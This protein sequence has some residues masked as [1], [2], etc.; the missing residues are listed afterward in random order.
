MKAQ[1]LYG[2]DALKYEENYK[3]PKLKTGEVLISVKACGICGSDVNRVLKNGTYH[4]PTIIGHEFSGKV[5]ECFDNENNYWLGRNVS[6]FPLIPCKVC[7]SCLKGEY[8]L[9]ENYNYLGSR[10]DGG[11]AEYVSVPAW[12]LLEMHKG[13]SFEEA[14]MLEPASV[15]LHS[16]KIAGNLFGKTIVITGTGTISSIL[17]QL[18]VVAGANKVYIIGRN[19]EKFNFIKQQCGQILFININDKNFESKI[20]EIENRIDVVVEGTGAS[21]IFSLCLRICTRQGTIVSLGNPNENICISREVYWQIL[22]KEILLRGTWNS[23]FGINEK[24]DWKDI[25]NL[26]LNKKIS[27]SNL[28]SHRF[29]LRDLYTGIKI[30]KEKTVLSNKVM[31]LL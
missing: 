26:L 1:V 7:A 27:L 3:D 21:E 24:N 6:V 8:Q 29:E 15:A 17:C 9:C 10:C 14:A 5:I 28:I 13:I 2:I 22:R 20:K 23:S 11:F 16:L 4:F 18:S 12:N 25:F 30:M 31:V 19:Q